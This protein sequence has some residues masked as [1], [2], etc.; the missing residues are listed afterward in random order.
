M[1][2]FLVGKAGVERPYPGEGTLIRKFHT[3]W[4]G[5]RCSY[6]YSRES[7]GTDRMSWGPWLKV[8]MVNPKNHPLVR[9]VSEAVA[10]YMIDELAKRLETVPPKY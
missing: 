5:C 2:Y 7:D 8:D 1:K 10:L 9:E 4:G 6:L 3:W